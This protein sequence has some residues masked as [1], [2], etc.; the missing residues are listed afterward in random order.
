MILSAL[1]SQRRTDTTPNRRRSPAC[2]ALALALLVA[3]TAAVDIGA[4]E[5][6]GGAIFADGFES[7]ASAW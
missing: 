7:G 2:V 4:D 3:P 6:G 1:T 5:L